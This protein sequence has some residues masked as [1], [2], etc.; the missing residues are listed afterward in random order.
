MLC[1]AGTAA[2]G[3]GG[4]ESLEGNT[5]AQKVTELVQTA[6]QDVPEEEEEEN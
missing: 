4:L 2:S 6:A 3:V 5:I 1:V